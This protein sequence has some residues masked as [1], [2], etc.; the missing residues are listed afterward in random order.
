MNRHRFANRAGPQQ[1]PPARRADGPRKG[2]VPPVA[3][4]SLQVRLRQS[5]NLQ[6]RW[7]ILISER[8]R[9]WLPPS[10]DAYQMAFGLIDSCHEPLFAYVFGRFAE[11][12][13][14]DREKRFRL[15]HILSLNSS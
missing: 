4:N 11:G 2:R 14:P 13:F 1:V 5:F 15:S 10:H 7:T 9:H 12:C 6:E 3:K 8:G